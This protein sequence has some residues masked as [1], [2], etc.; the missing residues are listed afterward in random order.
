MGL[1]HVSSLPCRPQL[2]NGERSLRRLFL[3][4]VVIAVAFGAAAAGGIVLR[5]TVLMATP[6]GSDTRHENVGSVFAVGRPV[7]AGHAGQ[8]AVCVVIEI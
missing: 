7:M 3:L 2:G 5:A 6:A 1:L 8:H 4:P